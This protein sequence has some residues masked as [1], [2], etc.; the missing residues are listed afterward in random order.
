M[1]ATWTYAD[2]P[3]LASSER[4]DINLTGGNPN[5]IDPSRADVPNRV[6]S[7]APVF[8]SLHQLGDVRQLRIESASTSGFGDYGT[9]QRVS[10]VWMTLKRVTYT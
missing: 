4:E 10:T 8:F 7:H 5:H 2:M 1:I 9:M 6:D 3:R